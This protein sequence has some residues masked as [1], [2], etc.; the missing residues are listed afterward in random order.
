[1]TGVRTPAV[2]HFAPELAAV[3]VVRA[4][5]RRLLTLWRVEPDAIDTAE[6]V[7]SEL[8]SNAVKATPPDDEFIAVRIIAING[9]VSV[10]VW[11]PP[12]ADEL[13]ATQVGPDSEN[14]R[15]LA[16]V[17]AVSDRW[18]AYRARDGGL[19][20]W[21]QFPGSILPDP[22][23]L[24]DVE[25][26]P[27]ARQP[28]VIPAAVRRD[29]LPVIEYSTAPAVL[30]RV[31]DRLRALDPWHECPTTQWFDIQASAVHA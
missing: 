30:A 10:E 5:T 3:P 16:I 19:V 9:Q 2:V 4:G 25:S 1:V 29:G 11:S 28:Q 21:A 13:V 12:D 14:G 31:A 15:G 18:N 23:A 22:E 24:A 20:V 6:L 8:V 7:V 27:P 26:L 17:E